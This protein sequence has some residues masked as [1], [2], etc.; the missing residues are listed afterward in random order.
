MSF[1]PEIP[2]KYHITIMMFL[3]KSF[4]MYTD[5]RDLERETVA[6]SRRRE[7]KP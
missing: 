7:S 1:N 2:D 6:M 5:P 4:E 3:Q